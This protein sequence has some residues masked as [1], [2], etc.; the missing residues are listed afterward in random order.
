MRLRFQTAFCI[1]GILC[2]SICLA[3]NYRCDWSVTGFGGGGMSPSAYKC[4]ATTGQT[5]V[6]LVTG[7]NYWALVG[8]WLPEGQTG[9]Q[10]PPRPE[11]R[12]A[13]DAAL[14]AEAESVPGVV[15][16]RYS[17]AAPRSRVSAGLRPS[18]P[19]G[20]EFPNEREGRQVHRPL[21]W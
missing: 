20:P 17:L 21:G 14:C 12:A 13:G 15:A 16:I 2:G 3:Q 8:Y 9:V 5:A 1:L 6:G 11:S 7:S 18:R 10:E 19:S 4:G